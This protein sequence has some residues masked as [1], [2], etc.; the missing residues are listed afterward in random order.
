MVFEKIIKLSKREKY[1]IIAI[2]VILLISSLINNSNYSSNNSNKGRDNSY[3][4]KESSI[5]QKGKSNKDNLSALD[6]EK[7]KDNFKKACESIKIDYSKIKNLEKKDDWNSGPRYTFSYDDGTF[8]LYALDNNEISSITIANLFMDKIYLDGYESLNVND[9]IFGSSNK[10][11]LQVQAED[12]IKKYVKNP[13][14]AS[15][16]WA[17]YSYGRRYNIYKIQGTFK[18]KND[19]NAK[20][21]NNFSIEFQKNDNGFET[22]LLN[23]NNKNYIGNKSK[24]V[25]LKRKEIVKENSSNSIELKDGVLGKY[26]KKDRFDGDYYIRYYVPAGTYKVTALTKNAKF[27]V[28]TKKLH[29]EDGYDTATTIKTITLNNVGD[30]GEFSITKDQCISLVVYTQIRLIKIK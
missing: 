12:I 15:F 13:S 19:F 22:V 21:D 29:K 20:I 28:E 27:Y 30:S 9:F 7:L 1:F 17:G 5:N 16:D 10:I 25:E 3:Q 4:N 2:I 8:V 18:A 26:G 11:S 24:I 23:I 6:N 14:S